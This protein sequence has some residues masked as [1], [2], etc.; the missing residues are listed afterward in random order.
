MYSD[1]HSGLDVFGL[2]Y[3]RSTDTL[4]TLAELQTQL[5]AMGMMWR[6][7][8]DGRQGSAR[9][10]AAPNLHKVPGGMTGYATEL[11]GDI[12]VQYLQPTEALFEGITFARCS[13]PA[14]VRAALAGGRS[15]MQ[16]K[17]AA[18]NQTECARSWGS[19]TLND[20]LPC[21]QMDTDFWWQAQEAARADARGVYAHMMQDAQLGEHNYY[22]MYQCK[23][24]GTEPLL[25]DCALRDGAA[26]EP[27]LTGYVTLVQ[28]LG[29]TEPTFYLACRSGLPE[30]AG[31]L[32][33]A[34][35]NDL[36]ADASACEYADSKEC[37]FLRQVNHRNRCRLLARAAEALGLQVDTERDRLAPAEGA[38]W[39][40]ARADFEVL[41]EDLYTCDV[42]A[43]ELNDAAPL[44][45]ARPAPGTER[46]ARHLRGCVD[47]HASF[48]PLVLEIGGAQGFAVFTSEP[49]ATLRLHECEGPALH[50]HASHELM[51][52][53]AVN[54]R[55][56]CAADVQAVEAETGMLPAL[57]I[58]DILYGVQQLRTRLPARV[59]A[60]LEACDRHGEPLVF[61]KQYPNGLPTALLPCHPL[62]Y[63]PE[64]SDAVEAVDDELATPRIKGVAVETRAYG[65]SFA[66]LGLQ[67]LVATLESAP[68]SAKT[69]QATAKK[70]PW[71]VCLEL[72]DHALAL[73]CAL[74]LPHYANVHAV[75][76][77]PCLGAMQAH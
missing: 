3:A 37:W 57:R 51:L 49:A 62:T 72:D 52:F 13:D 22:A 41:L 27:R 50:E 76:L 64:Q 23:L 73:L 59:C 10:F 19:R 18:F 11:G 30:L 38:G 54:V 9:V 2:L 60:L 15:E 8:P 31:P 14:A 39:R 63:M 36:C 69:L 70:K 12:R 34:L 47:A 66:E 20:L 32:V 1:G 46:V 58:H 4:A 21:A 61:G 25:A 28:Q 74:A 42:R 26:W 56:A 6:T 40:V 29:A 43:P 68:A 53:P 35:K 44:G 16:R 45:A 48:G 77:V 75:R 65:D 55:A 5:N 71:G 17:L 24:D 7:G 33:M 67:D